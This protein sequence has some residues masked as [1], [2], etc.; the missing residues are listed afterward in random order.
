MLNILNRFEFMEQVV[1]VWCNLQ[2][3]LVMSFQTQMMIW[4]T[5]VLRGLELISDHQEQVMRILMVEHQVHQEGHNE[6]IQEMTC[7][8][9]IRQMMSALRFSIFICMNFIIH[10]VRTN[11]HALY[12]H[13]CTYSPLY[14]PG[15]NAFYRMKMMM[16]VNTKCTVFKEL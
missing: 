11:R 15:W 8:W 7:L 6:A 16:K 10:R 4:I 9:R 3:T 12:L 2:C 5:G 14:W 1:V 13:S